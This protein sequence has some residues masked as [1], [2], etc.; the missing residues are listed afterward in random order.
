MNK[1][2]KLLLGAACFFG[3]MVAGFMIAPIKRGVYCGNNNGNNNACSTYTSGEDK[4]DLVEQGQELTEL[5]KQIK[6]VMNEI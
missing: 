5:N 6:E 3:G 4:E 2:E 1:K